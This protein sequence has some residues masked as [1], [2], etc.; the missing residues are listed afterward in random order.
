MYMINLLR[1]FWRINIKLIQTYKLTKFQNKWKSLNSHNMTIP[2]SIFSLNK[3]FIGKMCYG[4]LNIQEFGNSEEK[5]VI[6]NYISIAD[7]VTFILGGNHQTTTISSYPIY[8]K[9]ITLSPELD[10]RSKGPIVIEDEVW[11]GFSAIILSGVKIGRGAIIAA[12]SVVTKDIPA[13][14]IAGGNPAKVIKYRYEVDVI[15]ALREI[16]ISNFDKKVII[17]NIEEFYHPLDVNQ[18]EK[19]KNLQK[20]KKK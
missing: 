17:E 6:G 4:N 20:N 7:N 14:A 5:L 1:F 12:G 19:L 16:C 13:Y 15:D 8:S 3:V 2:R 11:I 10:A 18:I 9:L